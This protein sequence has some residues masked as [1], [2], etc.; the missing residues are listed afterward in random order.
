MQKIL[1]TGGSGFIGRNL[2]EQLSGTYEL[3]VPRHQD[4]DL[5]N[6]KDVNDYLT[7]ER[8]DVVIHSANVNVRHYDFDTSYGSLDGNLRMFFNLEKN[9]HLFGKMLYFGSGAEYD[10]QNYTP[11]MK[12]EYFGTYIPQDPYGF[13]K[14]IMSKQ[15]QYADNIYDLR[16]FGVY[17][18]YEEWDRRFISNIICRI[19]SGG[20]IVI[21]QNAV[22]DYLWINDL[23]EIVKWFIVHKPSFKHYNVCSG[24][25]VELVSL[26]K[27]IKGIMNYPGEIIVANNIMGKEYT[28][29]NIRLLKELGDISFADYEK[30]IQELV[31]FYQSIWDT[32]DLKMLNNK[33]VHDR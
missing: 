22:F 8:F 19:L 33:T 23:I 30:T 17:G 28:G 1:I 4:L 6:E 11:G 26:A 16:L 24:R 5:L 3:K 2:A 14:Y 12:E 18:K 32:L 9:R 31:V 7:N 15:A 20:P 29:D 10:M 21:H 27:M 13:S 25:R